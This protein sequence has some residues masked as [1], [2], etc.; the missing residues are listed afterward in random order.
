MTASNRALRVAVVTS[1][2]IQYQAPWF[3][4]LAQR[5]ALHVFFAHRQSPREQAAAGFGVDFDWDVDLTAGYA[6]AYL[7]N[8]SREPSVYTFGGCDTPE[9]HARLADGRFD[10]VIVTGWYLK[11]YAQSVLAAHRLRIPVLVRGDSRLGTPRPRWVRAVK[12]PVYRVGLRAFSGFLSVGRRH[13]EYLRHYGVPERR[14]FFAPHFVDG[15]HFRAPFS[16]GS[17]EHATAR[18]TIGVG[19]DAPL[20]LFVGRLIELKRTLDL[21]RA[22][23]VLCRKGLGAQLA[24]VGDGPLASTLVREAEREGVVLHLLGFRNQSALPALYAAADA[25]ALPSEHETWGLV[26]NEA[27]SCGLP[28]VV[29]SGVGCAP[30]LIDEGRTGFSYPCGDIPK[31][32][33]ALASALELRHRPETSAA[34]AA[35]MQ[36]YSCGSTV[37]GTMTALEALV[38]E[39]R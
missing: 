30:D 10:A 23:G 8:V 34:L 13:T 14:I 4:G 17:P 24:I 35:K 26:V 36:T 21:V 38:G 33:D 2:P 11:C 9:V 25:L 19:A 22:L 29:S 32:A 27:M 1:H 20:V 37:D 16:P 5:C 6:H 12:Q 39:R 3:R 7:K 18:A 15:E 28:A 31:L